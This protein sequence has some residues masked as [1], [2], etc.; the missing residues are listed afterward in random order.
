MKTFGTYNNIFC[1][2]YGKFVEIVFPIL[3]IFAFIFCLIMI[4]KG[5]LSA[6]D[7]G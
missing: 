3:L 2:I 5:V 6:D 1:F 4:I 7:T